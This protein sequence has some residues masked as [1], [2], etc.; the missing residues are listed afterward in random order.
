LCLDGQGRVVGWADLNT[1][2]EKEALPT[3]RLRRNPQCGMGQA[4]MAHL[5]DRAKKHNLIS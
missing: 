5:L 4:L 2:W 1:F 3:L